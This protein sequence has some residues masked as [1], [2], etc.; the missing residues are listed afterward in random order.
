MKTSF[1]RTCSISCFCSMLG[2]LTFYSLCSISVCAFVW[3]MSHQQLRSYGDWE[4][5]G[6]GGG[7]QSKVSSDRLGKPGNEPRT[8]DLQGE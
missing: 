6:G 7:A 4:G 8:S 3:L 1:I 2:L 5:G